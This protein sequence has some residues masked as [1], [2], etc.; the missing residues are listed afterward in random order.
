VLIYVFDIEDKDEKLKKTLDYWRETLK[1]VHQYNEKAHI[2]CLIHK[3]DKVPLDERK[4]RIDAKKQEIEEICEQEK[5]PV[6]K[7]FATSIWDE[8]LYQAWSQIV[9]LLI[10][11]H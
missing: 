4:K 3:I 8:T 6:E 7:Y 5:V 10:P 11:N 9:Q 2:F 1:S